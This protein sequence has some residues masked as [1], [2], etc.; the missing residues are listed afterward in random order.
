MGLDTQLIEDR[1]YYIV[2]IGGALAG[3]GGW[4]RRATFSG[5]DQTPGG[6][7]VLPDPTKDAA[8]IRAMHT[9]PSHTRKGV[10]RLIISL[11]EDAA[12]TEG[13]KRM[14]LIATLSGESL[15]RACGYQ[16]V[17][18]SRTTGAAFQCPF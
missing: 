12:R 1:I 4:S 10:R 15:C 8:R 7:A 2:E 3:C 5:G 16:P 6:S 18:T 17:E 9:H 11:C 14:E 13:Y